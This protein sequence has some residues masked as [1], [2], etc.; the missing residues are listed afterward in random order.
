MKVS[1]AV[2]THNRSRDTAEAVRSVL[3][4]SFDKEE[5]EIIVVDNRSTDDTAHVVESLQQQHPHGDKVHY[6]LE[7]KLGLSA[8]RNRA[9]REATGDFILFL[10]DDALASPNW[11]QEIVDVFE[12]DGAIGCVGGR[13]DPIWE[14]GE[15][16]WI[17]EEHRSVFTILDY[18]D[19]VVEMETPNIPYGANVAFRRSVFL[20]ISPFRED[21][22]RVGTKLLSSEESELI[23]RMREAYKVFYTPHGYV[24][25]KIAKERTTKKWFLKRIFWQG[26]SDAVRRNDR[27]G[28]A[29]I[30]HSVR[31]L[32]AVA[33]SLPALFQSRRFIR[34]IVKI[35]YRNGSLMGVL[36]YSGKG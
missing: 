35:C 27:A 23:G 26:V 2:C 13:I 1:V 7:Q 21:L 18:A 8:A 36:R 29:M 34:Q 10:D 32:Q 3:E 30:K 15:P 28:V 5:L 4:G 14:A 16:D 33:A 24:Q 31:M 22:G 6:F 25:H 9:I 11:A 20:H 17:P 19:H 12:R